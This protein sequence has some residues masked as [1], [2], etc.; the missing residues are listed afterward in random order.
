MRLRGPSTI[1]GSSEPLYVVDGVI[2]DNS[3]T[4]VT[5][6]SIDERG[7]TLGQNRMADINPNDIERME[8]LNGAA[9]AAIY[10]SRASNGVVLITTKKG[11]AGEP[12]Y[13]VSTSFSINEL[14]EEV[15]VNL[16][17][18]II[19]SPEQRLFPLRTPLST[20]EF[21]VQRFD[22]QDEI[23][24]VGLGTDNYI[25]AKGG[26]DKTTYFASLAYMRNEGIIKNTD[27]RRISG[28]VFINAGTYGKFKGDF[29]FKLHQ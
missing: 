28:K 26:T 16:T 14:R 11:E 12:Q 19:G 22:Y 3:T 2:L 23:F 6:T 13:F 4:N 5:N 7:A 8:I 24:D 20:D 10:G 15:P 29:R 1:S 18:I 27:F 9:A 17:P 25:S 21:E